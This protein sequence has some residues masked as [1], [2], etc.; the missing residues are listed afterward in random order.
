MEKLF[1]SRIVITG[2]V[3]VDREAKIIFT[4]VP[5]IQYEQLLLDNSF[6]QYLETIM[7]FKN[8]LWVR[9]QKSPIQKSYEI[10]V[11]A[12]TL[13]I[14]FLRSNRQ[15][16]W[17]EFSLMYDKSDQHATIYDSYNFELATKTVK[18]IRFSNFTEIYSL[19]NKNKL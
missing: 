10:N 5:F 18:S 13:E 11:G 9:A 2:A 14:D 17:L 12:D 16:D 15:F 1:E 8:I 7:V 19:T 3:S 4:R 6:R